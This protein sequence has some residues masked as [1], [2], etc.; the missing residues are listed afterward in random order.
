MWH[1]TMRKFRS[2]IQRQTFI[3]LLQND[4]LEVSALTRN[5]KGYISRKTAEM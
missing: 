5:I 2:F 4:I 3:H 1:I